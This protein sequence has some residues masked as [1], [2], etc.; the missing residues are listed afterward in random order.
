MKSFRKIGLLLVLV[1]VLA[2]SVGAT[3]C[4]LK[5][6]Y[7][8]LGVEIDAATVP[9]GANA[10]AG[11]VDLDS[12]MMIVT[13]ET[14]E[15]TFTESVPL[16][17]ATFSQEAINMLNDVNGG[18]KSVPFEYLGYRSNLEIELLPNRKY[19]VRFEYG[20]NY[21]QSFE[22]QN[23]NV[24]TGVEEPVVNTDSFGRTFTGWDKDF[25]CI[26]EDMATGNVVVVRAEY[27]LNKY[28][29][30]YVLNTEGAQINGTLPTEYTVEDEIDF[31]LY[32]MA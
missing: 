20:D 10:I 16:S 1:L 14:D 3:R 26:T 13:G 28:S 17:Q 25:T 29:I 22:Y 5:S 4:R 30:E 32:G 18:K 11:E 2:F 15:G 27:D 19:T 7:Y 12:I 9:S 24:L 31:E 6:D 23:V 8:N 21:A